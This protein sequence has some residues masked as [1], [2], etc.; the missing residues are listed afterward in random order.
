MKGPKK[1]HL[2][3]KRKNVSRRT[4]VHT[5]Q[6]CLLCNPRYRFFLLLSNI[7]E[8]QNCLEIPVR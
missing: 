6:M 2:D 5:V 3:L 1:L 7:C 4:T 8:L